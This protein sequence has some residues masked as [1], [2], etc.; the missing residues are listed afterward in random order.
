VS[1]GGLIPQTKKEKTMSIARMLQE[2][3]DEHVEGPRC[4]LCQES[5]V[6]PICP[7]CRVTFKEF[8][9]G[10]DQEIDQAAELAKEMNIL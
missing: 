4:I 7:K 10:S 1:T 3:L 2:I 8:L 5:R 6:E 9:G